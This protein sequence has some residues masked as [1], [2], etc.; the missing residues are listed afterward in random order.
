MAELTLTLVELNP[1]TMTLTSGMPYQGDGVTLPLAEDVALGNHGDRGLKDFLMW[2]LASS[3]Y[4]MVL[5]VEVTG[6]EITAMTWHDAKLSEGTPPVTAVEVAAVVHEVDPEAGTITYAVDDGN[7]GA[8][9]QWLT[10]SVPRSSA[11]NLE[12]LQARVAPLSSWGFSCTLLVQSDEQVVGLKAGPLY[13]GVYYIGR[14]GTVT[15]TLEETA[16]SPPSTPACIKWI[17]RPSSSPEPRRRRNSAWPG[18]MTAGR[19]PATAHMRTSP[20][21]A[22][23][24]PP[25][26]E[27]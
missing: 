3:H 4:P 2:S 19:S 21:A 26:R 16:P 13:D 25:M 18:W 20:S 27:A 23:T 7:V 24:A 12:L 9:S 17:R 6:G 22:R 11:V 10:A 1:D 14:I 5:E 8:D 15:A